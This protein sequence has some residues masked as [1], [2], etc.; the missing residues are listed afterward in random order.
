MVLQSGK[1][2]VDINRA[3]CVIKKNVAAVTGIGKCWHV[4][5][6]KRV[7]LSPEVGVTSLQNDPSKERMLCPFKYL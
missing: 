4:R 2:V 6:K 3:M 1:N 5:I 7:I